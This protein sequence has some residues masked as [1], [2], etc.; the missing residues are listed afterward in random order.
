[1][2]TTTKNK[3]PEKKKKSATKN[4]DDRKLAQKKAR[5]P[6]CRPFEKKKKDEFDIQKKDFVKRDSILACFF[7]QIGQFLP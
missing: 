6:N 3:Q 7:M 4:K 1:M 5:G 2:P